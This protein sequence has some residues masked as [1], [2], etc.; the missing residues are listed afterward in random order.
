VVNLYLFLVSQ[1]RIIYCT[2]RRL[3]RYSDEL[4]AG[5]ARDFSLL[6]SVQTDAEA[7]PVTYPT[8]PSMGLKRPGHKVNHSPPSI[9]EVKIGGTLTPFPHTFSWCCA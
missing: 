2:L 9:A 3:S 6:H 7:H 1:N 5:R 8:T 4:R